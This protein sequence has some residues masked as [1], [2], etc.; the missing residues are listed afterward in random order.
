[1]RPHLTYSCTNITRHSW[2]DYNF[3]SGDVFLEPAYICEIPHVLRVM[4]QLWITVDATDV[5]FWRKIKAI[6][7]VHQELLRIYSCLKQ[8]QAIPYEFRIETSSST[9]E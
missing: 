2:I 4:H 9:L 7:L 3:F 5:N 1:M 6:A 8:N